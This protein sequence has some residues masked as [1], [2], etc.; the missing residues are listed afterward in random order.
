M[1]IDWIE[2]LQFGIS[3]HKKDLYLESIQTF[4]QD[5]GT[6]SSYGETKVQ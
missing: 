3:F 5:I 6:I 1:T 4:F 2:N